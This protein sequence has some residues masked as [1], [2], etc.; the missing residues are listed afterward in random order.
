MGSR[1]LVAISGLGSIARQHAAAFGRLPGIERIGFDPSEAMR[2]AAL[3][4]GVV[5]RVAPSLEALLDADPHA[6]V[7]AAPDPW[8]IQQ[9]RAA[10]ARG[11]PTLVEKP[12]ADSL[13]AAA[14]AANDL[15]GSGVPVLVGYVLRHRRVVETVR[16][17]IAEGA[18]GD[19]ATFQ[20]MLGAYGTIPA[21]AS[22]F[23]TPEPDR[24]YRDYSHEWDYLRFLLSPVTAVSAV[25]RTVAV[26][27]HVESPN[28]VDALLEL[29]S[30]IVGAAHIDY[31]EPR[32]T[33]TLQLAGTEGVLFA[34]I[35]HGRISLRRAGEDHERRYALAESPAEPLARQAEHLLAVADG[36]AEPRVTL[37]DG[38]AALAVAD[39]LAR[40]AETRSWTAVEHG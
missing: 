27:G 24:L 20:V 17:L 29:R 36:E 19:V 9:L 15:A 37:T 26:P 35:R 5:E 18:I 32:G 16:A 10:V 39:A 21:A 38:V 13:S 6:V 12:L 31:V 34:D 2:D 23:A 7:V 14:T 28:A 33:R 30:G 25:A 3:A 1:R 8:H 40:S 11:I 4:D 22:R